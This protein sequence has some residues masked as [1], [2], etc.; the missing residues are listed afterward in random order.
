MGIP[1]H[2]RE[3]DG[4][5]MALLLVEM[6]AQRGQTLGELVQEMFDEL[7]PVEYSRRDLRL[8][9]QEKQAALD[10]M[11]SYPVDLEQAVRDFAPT[12]KVPEAIDRRDG[13]KLL[14]QDGSWLLFRASG[15]E[16]LIRVYAESQ[17]MDGVNALQDVGCALVQG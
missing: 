4:L 16:N 17:D 15:T 13:L 7:G 5:L 11:A 6:M 3:R 1:D 14:F 2:V 9:A 12:G 8:T 10:F